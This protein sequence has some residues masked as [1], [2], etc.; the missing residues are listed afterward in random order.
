LASIPP[1]EARM[2]RNFKRRV[3]DSETLK[4]QRRI[5]KMHITKVE[6]IR[7]PN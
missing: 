3:F 5:L 1:K 7:L 2:K 6:K 4:T